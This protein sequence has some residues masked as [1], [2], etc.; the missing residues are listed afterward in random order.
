M[1]LDRILKVLTTIVVIAIVLASIAGFKVYNGFCNNDAV[2]DGVEILFSDDFY[3][4]CGSSL[5]ISNQGEDQI[6]VTKRSIN[7]GE[8]VTV[9]TYLET[10]TEIETTTLENGD[11]VKIEA[12]SDVIY[13]INNLQGSNF[14][15]QISVKKEK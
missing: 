12:S 7:E 11:N 4:V 6:E 15:H 8:D 2:Y 5:A 1:T 14:D 3:G 10:T 13:V 9:E